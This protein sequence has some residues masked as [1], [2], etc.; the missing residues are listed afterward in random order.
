M[1]VTTNSDTLHSV[2]GGAFVGLWGYLAKL[3]WEMFI[4]WLFLVAIDVIVGVLSSL[5]KGEFKSRI[6]REGLLSKTIELFVIIGLVLIQRV[7]M[8][9]EVQI[10]VSNFGIGA[11]C[12]KDFASIIETA[13]SDGA[14]NIPERVLSWFQE[15]QKEMD[16]PQDKKK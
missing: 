1:N 8:L 11:F 9:N 12:F 2:I 13:I 15:A 10:L 3:N 5:K 14:V 4:I 6:M 7:A 16:L